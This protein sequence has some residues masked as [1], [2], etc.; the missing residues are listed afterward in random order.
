MDD[1]LDMLASYGAT[2]TMAGE[3]FDTTANSLVSELKAQRTSSPEQPG[4]LSSVSLMPDAN[5]VQGS[6]DVSS[7][8]SSRSRRDRLPRPITRGLMSLED[9]T[10]ELIQLMEDNYAVTMK[11]FNLSLAPQESTNEEG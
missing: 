9:S 11:L 7:F 1:S 5:S 6:G 10:A 8:N 3:V 4:R 2:I